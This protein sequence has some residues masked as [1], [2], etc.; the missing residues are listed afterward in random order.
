M[1]VIAVQDEKGNFRST[2]FHVRFGSFK[3]LKSK[4]KIIDI[5]TNNVKTNV[6]MKLSA[7]GDAYFTYD[8]SEKV[9]NNGFEDINKQYG[10]DDSENESDNLD[11]NDNNNDDDHIKSLD[12]PP[13]IVS[14]KT[15]INNDKPIVL[16]SNCLKEITSSQNQKATNEQIEEIF[17]TG[18]ITQEEFFK[19][20]WKVLNN[21][22]CIYFYDGN[23]LSSQE[24]IPLVMSLVLFNKPLPQETMNSLASSQKFSIHFKK[25]KK[26]AKLSLI[27]L[28]E[29]DTDKHSITLLKKQYKSFF[30]SS[31][32]LKALNLHYG[33]NEIQ[34]VCTNTFN[35]EQKLKCDLYLWP[36]NAKI[37][38]SDIDGTITRSDVLGQLM[39]MI[40][41]DWSHKGITDLFTNIS[42]N[43]Y[44]FVY[45]TARAI[46]QSGATKDY[47][48]T[49]FQEKNGL[50]RGP[51]LMSPDGLFSS[52][53]REVIDRSPQL[54]KI[55]TLKEIR[56]LFPCDYCPF[57]AGFGN[58]ETDAIAYRTVGMD[59]GK[60]FIVNNS[61]EVSQLNNSIK[62][63]YTLLNNI[64]HDIFPGNPNQ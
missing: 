31:S 63:N 52:F 24:A 33:R 45:L 2:S 53:K 37:V 28:H 11:N 64:V 49:L 4:E 17:L 22:N 14:S 46:C 21:K 9:Q 41:K 29:V 47:L 23:L 57:Y 36:S 62:K 38:I 15:T 32:Q 54:L 13:Q 58:R 10:E 27:K 60:I 51:L 20:P 1:D 19:N 16:V 61:G 34:F 42:E 35:G 30:P 59:M 39:P 26:L 48:N 3:V 5:Y 56:A 40:G 25:K 43:G 12:C 18:L 6:N 44:E 7:S 55:S 50:P 8:K